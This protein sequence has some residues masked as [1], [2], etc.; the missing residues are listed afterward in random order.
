MLTID[1][2]IHTTVKLHKPLFSFLPEPENRLTS[3]EAQNNS[4]YFSSF[5]FQSTPTSLR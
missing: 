1:S 5:Y 2:D 4:L 3:K